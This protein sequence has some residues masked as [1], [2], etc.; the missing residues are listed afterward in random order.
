MSESQELGNV[1]EK[2]SEDAVLDNISRINFSTAIRLKCSIC[3]AEFE[4][5]A[6]SRREVCS[7]KCK[8][9]RGRRYS[10]EYQANGRRM[11]AEFRRRFGGRHPTDEELYA[12]LGRRREQS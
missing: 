2:R 7:F 9:E 5:P 6:N 4:K 8:E 12:L 3:E 11:L 1:D 10:R